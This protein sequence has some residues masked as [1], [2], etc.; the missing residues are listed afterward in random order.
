MCIVQH[1]TKIILKA[2]GEYFS[3]KLNFKAG[4]RAIYY[5]ETVFVILV[6][7]IAD[8]AEAFWV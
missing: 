4:H 5:H 8:M 1:I 6:L 7:F 3:T 2:R